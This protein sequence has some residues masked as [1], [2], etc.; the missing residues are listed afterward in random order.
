MI[1]KII[2][3]NNNCYINVIIQLFLNNKYTKKLLLNS[4][5]LIINNDLI[6]ISK[7]LNLI[8]SNLNIN[9]QNDAQEAFI[10]LI[11]KIPFLTNTCKGYI[12]SEFKCKNCLK[13]RYVKEKFFNLNLYE[14]S[15][16]NSIYNYLKESEYNLEC[17]YCKCT[18]KTMATKKIQN[19]GNLLIFNNILK[20]NI[21]ISIYINFNLDKYRLIGYIKHLGNLN[22][23]HYIY[24][25]FLNNLEFDDTTI[26]KIK[27][28][29]L[30]NIYLLIYEKE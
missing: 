5:L 7:I 18:S 1:Y 3:F 11:E 28:H 21:E 4:D 17:D 26:R 2:N 19:I 30:D 9:N 13:S 14:V 12:N 20:L 24:Y 27:N 22:Y 23:G 16:E 15:M 8:K 29:T 6:D 25:D 10:F